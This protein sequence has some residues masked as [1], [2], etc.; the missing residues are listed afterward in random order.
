MLAMEFILSL[1]SFQC[2]VIVVNSG[3]DICYMTFD[4]KLAIVFLLE[5]VPQHIGLI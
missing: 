1:G 4:E 3:H 5:P 2:S